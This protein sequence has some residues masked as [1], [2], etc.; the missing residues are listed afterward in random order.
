M[1]GDHVESLLNYVFTDEDFDETPSIKEFKRLK[2]VMNVMV[3]FYVR[4]SEGKKEQRA[5]S[6]EELSKIIACEGMIHTQLE[7][8]KNFPGYH[9]K[10]IYYEEELNYELKAMAT[11]KEKIEKEFLKFEDL[12]QWSLGIV[13]TMLF[14]EKNLASYANDVL[15][16]NF[17]IEEIKVS[18]SDYLKFKKGLEEICFNLQESMDFFDA[19]LDGRLEKYHEIEKEMIINQLRIV[20]SYPE[21][22][23]R[24]QHVLDELHKD[25]EFVMKTMVVDDNVTRRRER[26]RKLHHDFF[27]VLKWQREK[28]IKILEDEPEKIEGD[29]DQLK[30]DLV[31]VI[32]EI[33]KLREKPA[34]SAR[35]EAFRNM[36]GDEKVVIKNLIGDE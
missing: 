15:E 8:L 29:V 18:V 16:T 17:E 35:V 21:D 7:D 22:N 27:A 23:P 11:Q 26:M 5:K 3:G 36:S 25:L 14:L 19:S 28:I 9:P 32:E 30:S 20:G 2:R 13:E 6:E 31:H 24:R 33:K 10:R 12:F 1:D 4:G 34:E